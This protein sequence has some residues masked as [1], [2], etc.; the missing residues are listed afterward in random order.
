MTTKSKGR[1]PK[2]KPVDAGAVKAQLDALAKFAA[3]PADPSPRPPFPGIDLYA[4]P[5]PHQQLEREAGD[6]LVV[7]RD[8]R[9]RL[10]VAGLPYAAAA[11]RADVV[12]VQAER[13]LNHLGSMKA[14][15]SPRGGLKKVI[16]DDV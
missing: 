1:K 6:L 14:D 3:P 12:V 15:P 7:A 4:V 11:E 13:I 8:L 9:A 10:E 2:G 5:V 16:G